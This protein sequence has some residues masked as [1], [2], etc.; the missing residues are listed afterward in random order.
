MPPSRFK[1]PELDFLKGHLPTW[2]RLK[3][4]PTNNAN[5]DRLLKERTKFIR[6]TIKAFFERFPE[7]DPS[8]N[9]PSPVTFTQEMLSEFPEIVR[10]W[11]RNNTRTPGGRVILEKRAK[12]NRTHARN[13][14]TQRYHQEINAIARRIIEEEPGIERMT[15]FNRATT[16]FL[17]NLKDEDPEAYA[18][19]SRD[20]EAI[21]NSGDTDYTELEPEVLQRLL[22]DF[23]SKLL[24]ELEEHARA[25]P[26]HIWCI[27]AFA[28]PPLKEVSTYT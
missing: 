4:R 10:Q 3:H 14:A 12:R 19:L 11:F 7:R 13:V 27:A 21:R 9:D 2:E 6:K 28:V 17:Q 16:E 23:P 15:A 8:V 24:N 1:P 20:A 5:I 22:S 26:V 18:Q 25:L